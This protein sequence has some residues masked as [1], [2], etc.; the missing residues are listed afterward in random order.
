MTCSRFDGR[1]TGADDKNL[2]RHLSV[3]ETH[4][5]RYSM[6]TSP[7]QVET[8]AR[9]PTASS[10]RSRKEG[11]ISTISLFAQHFRIAEKDDKSEPRAPAGRRV[12]LKE[13]KEAFS[14]KGENF[15]GFTLE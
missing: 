3:M 4:N 7:L 12:G 13:E 5:E 1:A 8:I 14:W 6:S 11:L 9:T 15:A 2:G 10:D